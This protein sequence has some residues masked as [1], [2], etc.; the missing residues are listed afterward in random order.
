MIS[1]KAKFLEKAMGSIGLKSCSILREIAN[2][3]NL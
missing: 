1:K 2:M 3:K